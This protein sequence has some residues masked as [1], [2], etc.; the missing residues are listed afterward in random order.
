MS[1]SSME[2]SVRA[3]CEA[4]QKPLSSSIGTF[5]V[6]MATEISMSNGTADNRV[7]KPSRMNAP[8]EISTTPTKGATIRGSGRWMRLNFLLDDIPQVGD[9]SCDR[10]K[11]CDNC[12]RGFH[13]LK[14]RRAAARSRGT[15]WTSGLEECQQVGI[16]LLLVSLGQA[17]GCACIDLQSRVFDEF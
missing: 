8:N 15:A 16:E 5:V 11:R 7:R 2:T 17:M 12:D 3:S 4:A 9:I 10:K 1:P 6:A 13:R 14:V